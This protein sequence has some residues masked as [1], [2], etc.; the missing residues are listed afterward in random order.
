MADVLTKEQRSRCMSRIRGR[1]TKPELALRHALWNRGLRY[2]I[3]H[4]LTGK[5]DIVFVKARVAIFVDG[6]FWH[7]CPEHGVMP[8]TNAKF[9]QRK[10][11]RNIER[12]RHVTRELETGGWK[13]LRI[14]EH[15]VK[16]EF[17]NII[18]EILDSV[19]L[20]A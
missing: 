8:K 11:T 4:G 17:E 3:G 2:R 19:A 12:D 5:P 7:G 10:I 1:D 15:R 14:W 9:W 13:V 20:R 18:V 6:C 16:N